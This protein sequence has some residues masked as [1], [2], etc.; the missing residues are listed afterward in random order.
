MEMK[1]TKLI[2]ANVVSIRVFENRPKKSHSTLRAKRATFTFW[3]DKS[4]LKMP[5]MVNF[6][7]F[8]KTWSL[9]SNNVTRQVTFNRTKINGKFQMRHFEKFSNIVHP[10]NSRRRRRRKGRFLSLI[11]FVV[12]EQPWRQE[13]K[14][15]VGRRGKISKPSKCPSP[16]H[17]SPSS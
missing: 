8:L 16:S 15:V 1:S 4:S 9:Q 14:S 5:K 3:V 12:E 2:S 17:L 11:L 7:E 13:T 10:A 6:G